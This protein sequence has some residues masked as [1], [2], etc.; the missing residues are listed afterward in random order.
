MILFLE[1][2]QKENMRWGGEG[3]SSVSGGKKA[4]TVYTRK[5][6]RA[7]KILFRHLFSM[8]I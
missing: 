5:L 3:E 2:K 1:L 6:Y 4:S 7:N 8:I